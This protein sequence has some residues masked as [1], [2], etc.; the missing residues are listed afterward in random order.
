M[1]TA[2]V[3]RCKNKKSLGGA[4]NACREGGQGARWPH[5]PG[6]P[7]VPVSWL[8]DRHSFPSPALRDPDTHWHGGGGLKDR[9]RGIICQPQAA[10]AGHGQETNKKAR[11]Q[12]VCRQSI[13]SCQ[14][15]G[16]LFALLFKAPQPQASAFWLQPAVAPVFCCRVQI[17]RTSA[18]SWHRFTGACAQVLTAAGQSARC[19]ISAAHRSAQQMQWRQ[20]ADHGQCVPAQTAVTLPHGTRPHCG[21]PVP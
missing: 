16:T 21:C 6:R 18:H 20:Q 2:V 19:P 14:H 5:A 8:C 15:T 17:Q 11:R 10:G 3:R 4:S 9:D 1:T 7:R 12:G 13:S